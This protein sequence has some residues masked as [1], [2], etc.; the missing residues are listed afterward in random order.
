MNFGR[1]SPGH[2][3]AAVAALALMFALAADWYTTKR[4]EELRQIEEQGPSL[5]RVQ[6]GITE[7]ARQK[8]EEEERNAWQAD[9]AIDRVL[10]LA[11]LASVL[12]AL[13]AAAL[14]AAARGPSPPLTASAIA[15]LLATLTELLVA[16]RII[17]EPGLDAGTEVKLGPLLAL[18][19][20]GGVT[21]GGLL[22]MRAEEAPPPEAAG[23]PEAADAQAPAA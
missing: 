14:R 18:I 21:A 8:A 10:L 13:T 11:A 15:V 20:L 2:W 22:A 5:E 23:A 4:G 19:C 1:L 6:P 3:L 9:G 7:E 16:Y 17:Q 12:A